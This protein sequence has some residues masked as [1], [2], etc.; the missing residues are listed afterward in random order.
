MRQDDRAPFVTGLHRARSAAYPPGEYVG[1][2]GFMR[3]GEILALARR[4]GIGPGVPVLDLCCGIAGPGRLITQEFSCTYLGL[5]LSAAAID[6]ARR[7]TRSLPARFEVAQVPP[8]PG[9]EFE[10]V[11]LLETMLAFADK[12][13]LL[14]EIARVLPVGGRLAATFEV[15]EPLTPA[16]RAA[17]PDADTVHLLGV[18]DLHLLLESAGLPVGW[19]HDCTRSHLTVAGS[20]LRQFM[21][22][23]DEITTHIGDRALQELLAAHRLWTRWLRS[24]R[25]RKV[26]LV[27]EKAP[28][29]RTAPRDVQAIH[30]AWCGSGSAPDDLPFPGVSDGT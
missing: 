18:S 8:L 16:E 29:Q 1:Q 25:V 28:V 2:E 9:G 14:G 13:A 20:L 7:R 11:L 17:M 15:G 3:A 12:R 5:D 23:A 10:V 27:A 6:I 19:E 24:G 21:I 30:T 4:A 26:A 22:R